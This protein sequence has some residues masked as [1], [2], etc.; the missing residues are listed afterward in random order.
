MNIAVTNYKTTVNLFP[1]NSADINIIFSIN[2]AEYKGY[3][4]LLETLLLAQSYFKPLLTDA[5]TQLDNGMYSVINKGLGVL[6]SVT[7]AILPKNI[8]VR[9]GNVGDMLAISCDDFFS[10]LPQDLFNIFQDIKHKVNKLASMSLG[11]GLYNTMAR[12]LL[13]AKDEAMKGL[14]GSELFETLI[15]PMIEYENFLKENGINDIIK[16]MEKLEKCLTKKGIG[17]RSKKDFM[18]PTSKK[19][20]SKHY[21]DLFILNSKGKVNI[22]SVGTSSK[23]RSQMSN[24]MKSVT[25]FRII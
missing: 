21:K 7:K 6:N 12:D 3:V 25:N 22:K 8:D 17:G 20:Y 13:K 19:L 23:N 18:H 16:R 10:S 4:S 11:S 15:S 2:Y 14:F 24:I 9:V 5:A 1:K